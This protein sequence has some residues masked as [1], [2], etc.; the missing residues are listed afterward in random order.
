MPQSEPLRIHKNALKHGLSEQELLSAWYTVQE[1]IR[2]ESDDEPPR[3]L[4]IGW[5]PDGRDVET[6]AVCL[7]DG[8]MIIHASAPAQKEFKDELRRA[9]RRAV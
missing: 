1:H 9:K 2:R 7:T 5:L 3:W 6:I 4:M 8:W